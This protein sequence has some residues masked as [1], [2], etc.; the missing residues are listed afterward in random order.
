MRECCDE[1]HDLTLLKLYQA[2]P[3]MRDIPVIA[4]PSDGHRDVA[5][6]ALAPPGI[7]RAAEFE[8]NLRKSARLTLGAALLFTGLGHLR[9]CGAPS[10]RRCRIL[11][12][13]Q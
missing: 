13:F 7:G 11:S 12:R 3:A 10:V 8:M 4:V 9:F 1:V 5:T 6:D 2:D